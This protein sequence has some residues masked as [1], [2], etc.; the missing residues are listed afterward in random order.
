MAICSAFLGASAEN[1]GWARW[2]ER[3]DLAQLLQEAEGE[4]G[5]GSCPDTRVRAP[6]LVGLDAPWPGAIRLQMKDRTAGKL[7]FEINN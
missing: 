1:R 2:K 4:K 3:C 6:G 5:R 7:E